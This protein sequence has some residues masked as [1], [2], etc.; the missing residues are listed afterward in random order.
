MTEDIT[1]EIE[2]DIVNTFEKWLPYVDLKD[3]QISNNDNN[4]LD[5]KIVFDIGNTPS[6]LPTRE[7]QT[8]EVSFVGVGAGTDTDSFK[9]TIDPVIPL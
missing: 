5:I 2:N 8:V 1:I 7:L 3:I 9:T 6:L 4:Q